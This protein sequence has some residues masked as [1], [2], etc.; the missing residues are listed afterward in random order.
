MDKAH[1]FVS[2]AALICAIAAV[3]SI[4]IAA[5]AYGSTPGV[6]N[7]LVP[8]G[9]WVPKMFYL[10]SPAALPS[11]FALGLGYQL[12]RWEKTCR[13]S[14]LWHATCIAFHDAFR[15]LDAADLAKAGTAMF[16]GA[17]IWM[18]VTTFWRASAVLALV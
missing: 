14:D 9:A 2:I 10:F 17:S 15:R 12:L 5:Y 3:T 11:F 4:A 1:R 16:A 7:V 6:Y 18:A 13:Q 8:S